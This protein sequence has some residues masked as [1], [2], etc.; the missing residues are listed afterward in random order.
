MAVTTITKS[1]LAEI[2][3]PAELETLATDLANLARYV[4]ALRDAAR[5]TVYGNGLPQATATAN[6]ARA[7]AEASVNVPAEI[8]W[9][10]E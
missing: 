3:D 8:T 1:T 2:S 7:V 5:N 9:G 4:R 10:S 6:L